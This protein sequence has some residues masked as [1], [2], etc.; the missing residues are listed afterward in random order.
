MGLCWYWW[1]SCR[2]E[3]KVSRKLKTGKVSRKARKEKIH[4]KL[5]KKEFPQS[6]Q[7]EGAKQ[8]SNF[9]ERLKAGRLNALRP[10]YLLCVKPLNLNSRLCALCALL[11]CFA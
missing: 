1:P 6:A 10:A 7:R 3:G 11:T 8:E 5:A 2:K 9:K 4:A